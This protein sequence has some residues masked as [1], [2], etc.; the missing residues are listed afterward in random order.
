MS[1]RGILG[2]RKDG[3]DRTTYNHGDSYP[4]YLGNKVVEFV[5]NNSIENLNKIFDRIILVDEYKKPTKKQ[6]EE[7]KGWCDLDVSTRK[8]SDWY[9]LLRKSQGN[10]DAYNRGLRYMID[11][12]SFIKSSLF[13][14]YGYIINLDEN[15]LEFWVGFQEKPQKGNR[16][17]QEDNNGYYPCKLALTFPLNKIPKNAVAQMNKERK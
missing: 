11:Y 3:K 5:K 17:G 8:A 12:Q 15:V 2:F 7:C 9:C 14:E 13:C 16:Y 10:L 6:I 1:T 4:D